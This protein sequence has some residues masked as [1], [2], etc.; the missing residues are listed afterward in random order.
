MEHL[1]KYDATNFLKDNCECYGS[2]EGGCR[3]NCGYGCTGIEN[4]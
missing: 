4:Y 1:F 2:C 3:T